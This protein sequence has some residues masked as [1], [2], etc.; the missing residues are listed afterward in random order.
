MYTR[1]YSSRRLPPDYG[2]TALTVN[3]Q[4]SERP[5]EAL[6][7]T[8]PEQRRPIGQT[9]DEKDYSKIPQ[10]PF[11]P[12]FGLDFLGQSGEVPAVGINSEARDVVQ[13]EE[14]KPKEADGISSI[15]NNLKSD[16]LLLL[17]LALLLFAESEKDGSSSVPT[18]ALLILA[19]LYLGG[20]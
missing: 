3:Q 10:P 19:M 5:R 20:L 9:T 11:P 6:I 12:P 16:D 4:G 1:S 15:I 2:G 7:Q 13:I 18:D 14:A 8:P 17:G